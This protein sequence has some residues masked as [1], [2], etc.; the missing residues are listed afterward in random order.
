MTETCIAEARF[1]HNR[2]AST[3]ILLSTGNLM[4]SKV[5]HMLSYMRWVQRAMRVDP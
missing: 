5:N 3:R 2:R 1:I 4:L